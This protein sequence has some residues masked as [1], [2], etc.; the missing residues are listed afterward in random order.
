MK[1]TYAR[2]L[3]K[4]TITNFNID[5]GLFITYKIRQMNQESWTIT[6]LNTLVRFIGVYMR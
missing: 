1:Q 5:N 3:N 4:F 6:L 2:C